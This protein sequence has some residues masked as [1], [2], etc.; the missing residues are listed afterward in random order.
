MTNTISITFD[1]ATTNDQAELGFEAWI[2]DV[3]QIDIARVQGKQQIELA[4][5]DTEGDHELRLILKGKTFA[6]TTLDANGAVIQDSLLIIDET[7]FDG[8]KLGYT[9][10]RLATY[11]HDCNGTTE[12]IQDRFHGQMGCNGTVSLKFTAPIYLWLLENM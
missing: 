2:D 10:T 6:H 9:M 5:P 4:M 11:V 7:A 8:V 1:L 3:K 12:T